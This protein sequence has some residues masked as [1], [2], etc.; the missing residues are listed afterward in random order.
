MYILDTA[1]FIL[2]WTLVSIYEIQ[3]TSFTLYFFFFFGLG[4]RLGLGLG[5]N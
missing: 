2:R 3:V 4:F 5:K 1:S